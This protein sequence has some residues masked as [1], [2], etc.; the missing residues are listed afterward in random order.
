[1][2]FKTTNKVFINTDIETV[3]NTI[4][5]AQFEQD[6]LPE[7]ERIQNN[8]YVRRTHKNVYRVNPSWMI[9]GQTVAWDNGAGMNIT[10]ARKDLNASIDSIQID[11]KECNN[12][13]TVI[14]HVEYQKNVEQNVV[15]AYQAIK[16]LFADKLTVLKNDLDEVNFEL[17]F[18]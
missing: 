3:W 12:G 5:N 9:E 14:V 18:A 6:F 7:I 11:V 4:T 1:M 13:V 8:D 16:H 17:A 2:N 15:K 10:L